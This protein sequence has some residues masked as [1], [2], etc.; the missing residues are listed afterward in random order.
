[1]HVF[2]RS[3]RGEERERVLRA[4]SVN[5]SHRLD[6]YMCMHRRAEA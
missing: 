6:K 2:W 4:E 5:E 3:K 1:M